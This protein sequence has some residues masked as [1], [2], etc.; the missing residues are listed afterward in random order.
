MRDK[1][2]SYF[3]A[4][5][6]MLCVF[7]LYMTV[8]PASN[9]RIKVWVSQD[10]WSFDPYQFDF[11]A[12]H[13]S[14]GAL[15]L[16]L[17]SSYQ[18]SLIKPA[19]ASNWLV[20]SEFKNW[21]IFIRH[22][23]KFSNGAVIS[24]RDVYFSIKRILAL[25][26]RNNSNLPLLEKI[27][28]ARRLREL[29]QSIEG[30]AY[31]NDSITFKLLAP[32]ANLPEILSFGLFGIVPATS[33]DLKT[34]ELHDSDRVFSG[35]FYLLDFNKAEKSL[36]LGKREDFPKDLS[37]EN[38]PTLIEISWD[39]ARRD[40]ADLLE[41]FE[42][43]P[44]PSEAR[45]F[46]G[47]T[48]TDIVFLQCFSYSND[49]SPLSSVVVRKMIRDSLYRN[50]SNAGF[51]PR[52]SLYPHGASA[53]QFPELAKSKE[54]LLSGAAIRIRPPN[55]LQVPMLRALH[56]ALLRAI[57]ELGGR[58]ELVEGLP[59]SEYAKITSRNDGSESFVELGS[60]GTSIGGEDPKETTKFMFSKEGIFLP[61]PTSSIGKTISGQEFELSSVDEQ[62]EKDAIVWPVFHYSN[63]FWVSDRLD[64]SRYN[65][66][67]P[68]SEL[69]WIG[70]K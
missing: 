25:A 68:L 27:V 14:M 50:L 13:V 61:D 4:L 40:S 5:A 41:G 36:K 56:N 53:F 7:L 66:S 63:G 67:L 21:K 65:T 17:F 3:F 24:A 60:R 29:N 18:D 19:A 64:L 20:T 10:P 8:Q 49:A 43:E 38:A 16:K 15:H 31:D 34:F 42:G 54:N 62:L 45:A 47:Y 6:T 30:L 57:S 11:A 46:K 26:V 35:P 69:Q 70:L 48:S 51:H 33:I 1:K 32:T 23:L 9:H 39:R 44:V 37:S 28:G 22:D 59:G 58:V 52:R 2:L 12:H 55:N